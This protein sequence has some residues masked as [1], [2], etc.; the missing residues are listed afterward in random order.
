MLIKQLPPDE[1]RAHNQSLNRERSRRA[2]ERHKAEA[3]KASLAA[4]HERLAKE[5]MND[6]RI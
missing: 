4:K 6:L 5:Y 3:R 2:R 1:L